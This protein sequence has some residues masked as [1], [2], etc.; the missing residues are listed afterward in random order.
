MVVEGVRGFET[1]PRRV[2][3]LVSLKI[4]TDLPFSGTLNPFA[5]SGIG[6]SGSAPYIQIHTCMYTDICMGNDSINRRGSRIGEKGGGDAPRAPQARSLTGGEGSGEH[7]EAS[8]LI[9]ERGG[10]P[11]RPPPLDPRLV[12]GSH[13]ISQQHSYKIV[14]LH[15]KHYFQYRPND[16]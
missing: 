8:S 3:L 4:P 2:F 9:R 13:R 14:S 11:A 6:L 7:S 10:A 1:P 12:Y 16:L 15:Q 5:L